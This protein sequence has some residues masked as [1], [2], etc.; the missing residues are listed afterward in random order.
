MQM[1]HGMELDVFRE[2][3]A[4]RDG[5]CSRRVYLIILFL[6]LRTGLV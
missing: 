3:D 4:V 1:L 5:I 2:D 6:F